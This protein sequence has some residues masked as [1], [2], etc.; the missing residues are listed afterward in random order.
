MEK[1]VYFEPGFSLRTVYGGDEVRLLKRLGEVF[2]VTVVIRENIATVSGNDSDLSRAL[3]FFEE[4]QK[5]FKL[6]TKLP[7]KAE[8]DAL[9]R[10]IA[11]GSEADMGSL[12]QGRVQ[13]GAHKRDILPRSRRQLEYLQAMRKHDMV[14]GIGPAGTGKTYLAMA[15]AVSMLLKG[16]VSRIVLTR[17]ARE[18]GEKLGFLPGSLEEK[19][20]PYLRPLYDALYEMMS[21][22]EV[23]EL[24]SRN[25]IE[26]APLAFM[27]GRTLNNAFIILDEA[28]NTTREQMLMFLT[29]MG[30]GSRCV[31]TGD[32]SQSDL[33]RGEYPGLQRAVNSLRQLP[34]I[35]FVFFDTG[36]VVR[37][38]LL[39]KIICAYQQ[40][41]KLEDTSC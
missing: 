3:L 21:F 37:H 28:Q 17:P 31:I 14:F 22:E 33:N 15:M 12:W 4:L 25:I 2:G 20:S 36:D 8:V 29:R 35:G 9:L 11:S 18:T 39:E 27:R 16:E 32:P 24:I 41:E 1:K 6:S 34:E 5:L 38:A 13:L 23:Q 26:V 10:N 30:F 40:D 7:E 19:I